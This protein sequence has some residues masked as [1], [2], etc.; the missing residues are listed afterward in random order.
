MKLSLFFAL[1]PFAASSQIGAGFN[2]G[3]SSRNAPTIELMTAVKLSKKVTMYPVNIKAHLSREVAKPAII[4][5]RLSYKILSFE[6]YGGYGYHIS[7]MD[8]DKIRQQYGGFKPG[9]GLIKH[10]GKIYTAAG[11]S[12]SI[13]TVQ[14]GL[15]GF[16]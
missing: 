8:N 5:S 16:K 7:S 6:L 4:E 10:F 1:I 3:Y 15:F 13:F 12:G 11:M 2:I 14:I 9:Y